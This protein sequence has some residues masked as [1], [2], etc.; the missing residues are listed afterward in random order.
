MSPRDLMWVVVAIAVVAFLCG[1]FFGNEIMDSPDVR[2]QR[3]CQHLADI[4]HP[5]VKRASVADLQSEK[6]AAE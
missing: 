4:G 6:D 2:I 5:C 3:A 1:V